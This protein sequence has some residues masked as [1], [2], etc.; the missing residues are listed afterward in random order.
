[1]TTDYQGGLDPDDR[2]DYSNRAAKAFRRIQP[3]KQREAIRDAIVSLLAEP[4]PDGCTKLTNV[5]GA[6]RIRVGDYRIVYDILDG[7]IKILVLRI[8]TRGDVYKA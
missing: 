1:M 8:G 2:I 6:Y 4:G 7:K 3:K 5:D